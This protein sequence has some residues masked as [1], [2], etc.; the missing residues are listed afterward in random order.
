M[1]SIIDSSFNVL[2]DD[3][4]TEYK[5]LKNMKKLLP[6]N[7]TNEMFY[8]EIREKLQGNIKLNREEDKFL[9]Y[10]L[11]HNMIEDKNLD[12]D[13]VLKYILHGNKIISYGTFEYLM[14]R[15]AEKSMREFAYNKIEN[16]NPK[17]TIKHLDGSSNLIDYDHVYL[18]NYIIKELY[19]GFKSHLNTYYHAMQRVKQ[20][21][22]IKLGCF[23]E[24]LMLMIKDKVIIEEEKKLFNTSNYYDDNYYNISFE[25][26]ANNAGFEESEL[27]L[28]LSG[29]K[30]LDKYF[31]TLRNANHKT[32]DK[33]ERV[34][35]VNSA[36][37][38]H[39]VNDVFDYVIANNPSY[40]DKYKQ[41]NIEYVNDSGNV[42]R[43]NKKELEK[44][45]YKYKDDDK[46]V[47]Y[48]E[49]L[50]QNYKKML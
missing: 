13:L 21:I 7:Y 50:K 15:K 45:M 28:R 14:I 16:Y 42:R 38:Y 33:L 12:D 31:E 19:E 2:E 34:I 18:D 49:K 26:D 22:A 43:K 46:I 29:Y 1:N 20:E 37:E 27:F 44:D 24:D 41:L 9:Y 17:A 5:E 6:D 39:L 3:L 25:I 40:L 8:N 23:S 32:D 10:L 48:V 35:R 36:K 47:K 30:Y 11:K 4:S